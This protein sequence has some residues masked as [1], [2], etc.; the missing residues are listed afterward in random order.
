SDM[1]GAKKRC[2]PNHCAGLARSSQTGSMRMRVPSISSSM[3]E[4]PNHVTRSPLADGRLNVRTSVRNGPRGIFRSRSALFWKYI[5][6]T[7]K[8]SPNPPNTVGTGFRYFPPCLFA[9]SNNPIECFDTL[10]RARTSSCLYLLHHP[11][12]AEKPRGM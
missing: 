4:W 3:D 8:T 9:R 7:L 2:G 10:T 6:R 11:L 1:V 5:G 12:E